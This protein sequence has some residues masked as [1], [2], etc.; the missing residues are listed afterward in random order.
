MAP[1]V[2]SSWVGARESGQWCLGN[3]WQLMNTGEQ[4]CNCPLSQATDILG[5]SAVP[6]CQ[7][8]SPVDYTH[9]L[10]M[11]WGCGHKRHTWVPNSLSLAYSALIRHDLK[12]RL[13]YMGSGGEASF[14]RL[15]KSPHFLGNG[16]LGV[17]CGGD[18]HTSVSKPSPMLCKA[19][20]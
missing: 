17:V 15:C 13:E 7:N 18:T 5:S 11:G 6:T 10:I 12:E 19:A 14:M 16:F 4:R 1:T 2:K 3:T 9:P 20:R 8:W